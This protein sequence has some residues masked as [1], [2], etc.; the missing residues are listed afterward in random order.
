LIWTYGIRRMAERQGFGGLMSIGKSRAKVYVETDTKVTFG[1]VAGV[2]EAKSELQ[3]V[4]AF[5]RDPKSFGRLG[6]PL[7]SLTNWMP[8]GAAA[9]P[10]RSVVMT[11]RS[12]RSI[13]C[14]PS[15]MG[16]IPA[17]A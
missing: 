16:L 17:P 3:E 15:W 5:L 2:D 10:A 4:L 12:R 6:A 13:S 9:C 1:N 11:K 8:W 7:S 14:S